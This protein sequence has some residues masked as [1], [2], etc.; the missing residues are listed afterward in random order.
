MEVSDKLDIPA[1]LPPKKVP[2]FKRL[3]GSIVGLCG[4]EKDSGPSSGQKGSGVI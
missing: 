4:E 3:S 2:I 1:L